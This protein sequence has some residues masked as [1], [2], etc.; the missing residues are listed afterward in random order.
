[1]HGFPKHTYLVE[2]GSERDE[3]IPADAPIGRLDPDDT[4]KRRWLA[5]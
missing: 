3:S 5:Y 1:M 4:A 2:R